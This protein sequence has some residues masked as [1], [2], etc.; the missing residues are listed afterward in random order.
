MF[1]NEISGFRSLTYRSGF[2]YNWLAKRMY[3][4]KKKFLTIGKLIGRNKRVLDIPCGTGYLCRFLDPSVEYI[5][6]DLNHRFLKK[7]TADADRGKI[8]LKSL[9]VEQKNIFDFDNYPK[10]VDVVVLCDILHHITPRHG[11]LVEHAKIVA[12]KVIVCEPIAVNPKEITARDKF[13]KL[14]VSFGR[15]FPERMIQALDFFFF[16]NDGLNSYQNRSTW[17]HD[18]GSLMSL[19]EGFGILKTSV[20]KIHDDYIG[21]WTKSLSLR[22]QECD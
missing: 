2:V 10:D 20:F 13:F 21:V 14:V 12:K 22:V 15:L 19:Y 11:D 1:A 4:Q 9:V 8:R 7:I 3:D 5:G 18:E 16:D 6:F 17:N